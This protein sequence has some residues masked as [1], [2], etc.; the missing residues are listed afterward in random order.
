MRHSKTV[1]GTRKDADEALARAMIAHSNDAPVP[2][3]QQ[4]YEMWYLPDIGERYRAGEVSRSTV[5]NHRSRWDRHIAPRFGDIPVTGIRP[6]DV[7]DWLLGLTTS[8]A[9][10]SL[11]VLR[12]I[13]AEC[14]LQEVVTSNVA[15]IRYRMPRSVE[16]VHSKDVYDLAQL[17]AALRATEG[18][19]AY[20]PAVL[21]GLGSCRV[22]ESL[23]ARVDLGE[24][25][26]VEVSGM[27]LAVV[28]V[29]RQI[30]SCGRVLDTLKN[31]QSVRP[32]VIPEPWSE[33]VL[34][35]NGPWLCDNGLGKPLGQRAVE[36]AWSQVLTSA[37][38]DP[39]PFRNLR[40][41]WRT[42][43]RWELG[44]DEDKVER[45]MGHAG[46]N[47]GEIHYDRPKEEMFAQTVADAWLL[48]RADK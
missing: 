1:R 40:N 29:V 41:S 14:V 12:Q 24:A 42:I 9:G 32:V 31:H 10:A 22:G 48:Y 38:I 30:D 20:L 34:V 45:M 17:T 47:I 36:R 11:S 26:A 25:R 21:C 37:G 8:M 15:D 28:D 6:A 27:T 35:E 46:K 3:L 5:D 18:T 43:M 2:T 44:V 39:I 23:G 13:L 16:R 7:Q 33:S 19:I 4:A